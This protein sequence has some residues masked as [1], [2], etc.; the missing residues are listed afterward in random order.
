[1]YSSPKNSRMRVDSCWC[2]FFG[3]VSSKWDPETYLIKIEVLADRSCPL[4]IS[5]PGWVKGINNDILVDMLKHIS[6][7]H[8]VKTN[9]CSQ[10]KNL[11][12][13]A[14]R[15]EDN[16]DAS[17]NM[18]EISS[19]WML[20]KK[21]ARVILELRLMAYFR[22]CFPTSHLPYQVPL[23]RVKV[24]H[25]YFQVSNTKA[26]YSLNAIIVGLAVSPNPKIHNL[27]LSVLALAIIRGINGLWRMLYVITTVPQSTS[28]HLLEGFVHIPN[29][30]EVLD[31]YNLLEKHEDH[32]FPENQTLYSGVSLAIVVCSVQA[33]ERGKMCLICD[34]YPQ[35]SEPA[36]IQWKPE[37]AKVGKMGHDG[38]QYLSDNCFLLYF[39][40]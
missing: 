33:T 5:T 23:P 7:T 2:Y 6:P 11:P 3:S 9:I 22:Q 12:P 30:S 34:T 20:V 29:G 35:L 10:S 27:C 1:M 36:E 4:I 14:F 13:R 39:S 15:V 37:G 17:D 8:V 21:E 38:K 31:V 28:V 24:R 26:L 18:I 32:F 40:M 16:N 19:A 25:L